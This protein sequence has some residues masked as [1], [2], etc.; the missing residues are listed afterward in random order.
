MKI[1]ILL[2]ALCLCIGMMAQ[3]Q[4]NKSVSA[5][6][7]DETFLLVGSYATSTEEGIKVYRFDEQTGNSEYISG[8][9]GIPNPSFLTSSANGEK[10]YTVSEEDGKNPTA[11]AIQFD[12]KQGRLILLNSRPTNGGLPCYITLSPMEKFVLT[13]NYMGGSITVFA[14][15]KDGEFLS[16]TYLIPFTG[17]G[18]NKER[19]EQPHLH[20]VAFTPDQR[21][22][23]ATD[24]GTD[25]IYMFPVGKH[26]VNDTARSLLNKSERFNMQM[27][28]GSGP[29]HICFHPNGKFAYLI[30]ELSGKITVFSYESGKLERLQTIV[31]DPFVAC[32]SADIHASSDGKFLYAS[33]RLKADGI[34]IYS[35]QPGKGTLIQVGYQQ[36]GLYPRNFSISRSGRYLLVVCRDS[37][38][39]QIFERNKETGLLNDTKKSIKLNKPAFIEFP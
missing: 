5:D 28:P 13:A 31:C 37:N 10:I 36:T 30:S 27:D 6:E 7:L 15:D 26:I 11:N 16:D 25:N 19:Q 4:Q 32:G 20:C 12:K 22:L 39:I 18:P 29:R 17:N 14:L 9:K 23:L 3:A 38:C 33:N 24:L 35:I 2:I 21:Y 8:L 1:K 34:V